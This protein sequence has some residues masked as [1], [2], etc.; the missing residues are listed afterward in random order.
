MGSL[1]DDIKPKMSIAAAAEFLGVS[2]QAI[3]KQL[4]SKDIKCP[5]IGNKSYIDHRVARKLFNI[6]FEKQVI[7]CQIVKGGVGKTTTIDYIANCANAYGARVLK[8]DID[9]Q[10][11]LTDLNGIDADEY[12]AIVDLVKEKIPVKDAIAKVCDGIDII[13]SRIENVVLDGELIGKRLN[14][15]TFFSDLLEPVI[16]DYDFI[17]I[18]CPPTIGHAVTAASLFSTLLIAPLNPE[19]FSAKGLTI[20]KDEIDNLN[21]SFKTDINYK[22]FLNKFSNKTILSEKTIMSLINDPELEGRV[23]ETVIPMSQEIPNLS[24]NGQGA[25]SHLK[26]SQVRS[27]FD[28][29]TREILNITP[30]SVSTSNETKKELEAV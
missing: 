3:H 18:D 7:V 8:I 30:E 4:K 12:P 28:Q 11:N 9:P 13:P 2:T 26:K 14:V 23:V 17:F 29:L 10:G 1:T 19:K 15:N 24:H 20:L 6:K 27:D 21:K 16:D 22:V 25:F 5:K